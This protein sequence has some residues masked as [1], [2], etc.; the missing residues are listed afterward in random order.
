[1]AAGAG[2]RARGKSG[3]HGNT[4]PGNTRRGRPQ[5]KCHREHTARR[6]FCLRA[7]VKGCGKSAP[8]PRRRGRHG[9]P[10]RE[11]DRVGATARRPWWTG[12]P[13]SGPVARVGR[14]R[15]PATGIPEEWPSPGAGRG[16]NPAYRPPPPLSRRLIHRNVRWMGNPFHCIDLWLRAEGGSQHGGGVVTMVAG[17]LQRRLDRAGAVPGSRLRA[18]APR[19]ER[20]F[21]PRGKNLSSSIG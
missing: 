1:M 7:R 10:H 12:R 21:G 4:V 18:A 11:Q 6:G 17:P 16:Q 3:L 9:K 2:D 19:H 8:R 15:C 20:A 13:V 14:A 5:G